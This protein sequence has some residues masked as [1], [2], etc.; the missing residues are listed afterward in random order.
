MY[1]CIDQIAI[2]ALV[3]AVL[4]LIPFRVRS[5]VIAG[6]GVLTWGEGDSGK[7]ASVHCLCGDISIPSV[8]DPPPGLRVFA[9]SPPTLGVYLPDGLFQ[10]V[11]YA[12]ED[13]L[14]Y[15]SEVPASTAGIYVV[16]TLQG[17]CAKIRFAIQTFK[18]RA[19][20]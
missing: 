14:L 6:A 7:S 11:E 13:T 4:F 8:F 5:G 10:D 16:R 19:T 3:G 9:T 20:E 12:A 1:N 2:V 15:G 18:S 17:G